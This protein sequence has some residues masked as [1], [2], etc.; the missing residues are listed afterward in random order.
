MKRC[1]VRKTYL[2]PGACVWNLSCCLQIF[3][4]QQEQRRR[5]YQ[6]LL[7]Q[8]KNKGF[9]FLFGNSGFFMKVSQFSFLSFDN[10]LSKSQPVFVVCVCSFL[11]SWN[12]CRGS[13]LFFLKFSTS[14]Q[15]AM[16][17]N[18]QAKILQLGEIKGKT[19]TCQVLTCS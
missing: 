7:L 8:G 19:I 14:L 16:E 11:D 18:L 15:L 1:R 12:F 10:S 9:G 4:S 6:I 17:F 13:R 2:E 3:L 5:K